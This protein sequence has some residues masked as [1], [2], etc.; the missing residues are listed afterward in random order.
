MKKIHRSD[1]ELKRLRESDPK[2]YYPKLETPTLSRR[3]VVIEDDYF[4]EKLSQSRAK[5]RSII[6]KYKK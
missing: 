3:V 1:K 2:G 4:K 5:I 6:E